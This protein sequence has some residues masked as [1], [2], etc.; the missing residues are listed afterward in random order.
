MN[1]KILT[2]VLATTLAVILTFTNFIMLGMYASKT[3]ATSD[4]LENQ[5]TTSNNENVAFDAYFMKENKRKTH[6]SIVD[7]DEQNMKIYLEVNVKK[8]YLKNASVQITGENNTTPNFKIQNSEA[9]PET[10]E[11]IDVENNTIALK[12][13]NS[14]TRSHFRNTNYKHKR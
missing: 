9:I 1:Q 2:K 6:S 4:T 3:Y 8:G 13:I 14:G 5:E 10:V 12:Q 7:F 11:K